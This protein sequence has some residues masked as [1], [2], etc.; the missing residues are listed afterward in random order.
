MGQSTRGV[1][2]LVPVSGMHRLGICFLVAK[3]GAAK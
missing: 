3:L 2:T 1:A